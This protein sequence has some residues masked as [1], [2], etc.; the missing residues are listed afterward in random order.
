M[1]TIRKNAIVITILGLGA[2][3]FSL[4]ASAAAQKPAVQ[5]DPALQTASSSAPNTLNQE[6]ISL[7]VVNPIDDLVQIDKT[8]DRL[9]RINT[10]LA[11]QFFMVNHHAFASELHEEATQFVLSVDLPGVDPKAVHLTV[12][13]RMLMIQAQRE[14]TKKTDQ[15]KTESEA[16]EYVYRYRFALPD[17]ADAD[18]ITAKLNRGVLTIIL[19]KGKGPQPRTILIQDH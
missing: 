14:I 15:K 7:D 19:P 10:T 18:K 2:L 13:N 6:V 3:C 4:S 1:N 11:K 16:K 5:A 17:S 8:F 9:L 12:Q